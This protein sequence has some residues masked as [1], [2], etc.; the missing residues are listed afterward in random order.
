MSDAYSNAMD[1][2]FLKL[3]I[4]AEVWPTIDPGP[5][6]FPFS[7]GISLLMMNCNCLVSTP[8]TTEVAIDNQFRR[9]VAFGEQTI[10]NAVTDYLRGDRNLAAK[11]GLPEG[12][13]EWRIARRVDYLL[14]W[15]SR[16]RNGWKL[17]VAALDLPIDVEDEKDPPWKLSGNAI[18]RS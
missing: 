5:F 10:V 3:A 9:L 4:A 18:I 12:S 8:D 7:R 11:L 1:T 6:I 14:W 13:D 17:N 2:Q 15:L 16:Q